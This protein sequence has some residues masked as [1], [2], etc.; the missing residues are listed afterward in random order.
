MFNVNG[1]N[2]AR[3]A[4]RTA[5]VP[6]PALADFFNEGEAVEFEVR[7]LSG[8]EMAVC[9]DAMTRRA[10]ISMIISAMRLTGEHKEML[11]RLLGGTDELPPEIAK[12]L[13]MLNLVFPGI[14]YPAW[15]KVCDAFPIAFYE[16]TNKILEL[17]GLGKAL[18]KPKPSGEIPE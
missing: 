13:E 10:N 7:S 6:V 12:R 5:A 9:N 3:F 1:F 15:I 4:P 18:E 8:N 16:L 17:T 11:D 14:G 2:K